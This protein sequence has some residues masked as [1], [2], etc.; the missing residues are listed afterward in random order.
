MPANLAATAF[1]RPRFFAGQLLTE[2]DLSALTAYTTAKDRLHNRYLFGAGVVCG[3]WVSCDPCG[4]G[5]VTVQPGYALDCCGDDLILPCA[6]SLDVNAMIRD[7]RAAQLGK[8]CG[9]PCTDQGTASSGHK[10]AS[11][12]RHYCLYARYGEQAT[13]PVAPYAT[14]EPC[15]Q[16]ACEPTRIQEGIG[17]VLKCPADTPPTDD[18]WCRIR[19]CLPSQD[20]LGR[21]TRLKA[22]SEPMIA[23]AA[24]AAHPPSF[25]QEDAE[26]LT[27]LR[28]GLAEARQGTGDEQIRSA[29]EY[30]RKLAAVLA[31][32]DLAKERAKYAGITTARSE[33]RAAAEALTSGAAA[34]RYDPPDRPAVDALLRQAAGL[35]GLP[36]LRLAMLT[37]GRP[38]DDSVLAD[39]NSDAAVVLEWLLNRLDNDPMLADCELRSRAQALSLSTTAEDETPRIRSLGRAGSE[40]AEL[41]AGVVTDCICAALD[42][43]CAPCEDT[44]VLLACLEVRDCTVVRICNAERDYV[45]SGSALRYWLPAGLLHQGL[46][47]LCCRPDRGRDVARIE[48]GRLAFSEAGFGT[49]EPAAAALRDLLGLPDAT[50]LLRDAMER[51]GAVRAAPAVPQPPPAPPTASQAAADQATQQVAALAGRVAELDERL[52]QTEAKLGEAETNLRETQASLGALRN[53]PPAPPSQAP[54]RQARTRQPTTRQ[55]STR[56]GSAAG[57]PA[58]APAAAADTRGPA[59]AGSPPTDSGAAAAGPDAPETSDGT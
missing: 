34:T 59:D 38:V 58:A 37:Q 30:V 41:V 51:L 1:V 19:A 57:R 18:L 5:T 45:I 32:Y 13:D 33:L 42:P 36:G 40:L 22:Y 7:L 24:A 16:V 26:E 11:P 3:L 39:L 44:D 15:G 14:G 20:I 23:A 48:P 8:D 31:R 47:F 25:A 43:P 35:S 29:T 6:T 17:F 52:K 56:R 4:G 53:Q 49:G 55:P 28:A 27:R 54:P 10:N 9:D 12:T 21:L 50:D 2:D 46:E